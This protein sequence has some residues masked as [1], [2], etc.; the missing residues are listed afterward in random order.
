MTRHPRGAPKP[1]Y[2][3]ISAADYFAS[4]AAVDVPPLSVRVYYT[5]PTAG[6]PGTGAVLVCHHGAGYSGLSFAAFA[7]EVRDMTRGELGVLAF[8]ARRHGKDYICL[9]ISLS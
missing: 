5:P 1:E 8:D 6:G 3:P 4:A 2:A 7:R 9:G